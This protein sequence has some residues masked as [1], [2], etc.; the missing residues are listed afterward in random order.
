MKQV[1]HGQS[2]WRKA[3]TDAYEDHAQITDLT[4]R[5]GDAFPVSYT[6]EYQA[7]QCVFDIEKVEAALADNRIVL[8]LYRPNDVDLNKIRLKVYHVGAPITLSEVMPVL[9]NMGLRVIA[10]LPFEVKP[11]GADQ[12]VWIH[13]FLLETPDVKDFV[14]IKDVK[15]NFE[16]AFVKICDNEVENDGLNR[17][18]LGAGTN[19]Q[20]TTILRAYV[21][22]IKQL[23]MPFSRSYIEKAL[24]ENPQIA[25]LLISMFK[26]QHDPNNQAD[27]EKKVAECTA[28]IESELVSVLSGDFDR[29]LRAIMTLIGCTLRTNYYQ[30]QDDGSEKP[31]LSL[32]FDSGKIPFMVRPRPLREIF[33]YSPLVEAIHLRGDMIAR[34]GLRWSDRHEDYR[35][36]VLGLMK[37]QMVKNAVIVPTGSKGGFVVK[38]PTNT[39]DEF[40][41]EGVRCYK[42]FI[43]ALLEITDNRSGKKII[44]PKNVVRREGDDPYLV[45]AADKGTATFSDI[46]NGLSQDHGFWLDDAFASGG[47][48]G[49]DHKKMGIT[50]RGAW[51]SVKYHFRL[52]NHNTQTEEFE[53][54][55][56]GD[57]GGD[58]F[59]NGMLLSEKIRLSGAF[60]HLHIF[61]DPDPDVAKS[62]KERKR[63]FDIMGGWDKYNEK[64]LSKGGRIYNRSE[65][66]LTLTPE[67]KERFDL[68]KD[69]VTPNELM[70]AMLKSRTDLL[71]FGGIGTYIKATK[72]S[73][74]A[75]GDKANDSLRVNADEVRAKVLGEGA[76]LGITQL[77]RVE[78]AERG[79]ALNTDFIDNSAGVDSSDHEVN[80]KIL[81]TDVMSQKD[82]NMDIKA[83]NKLLEKMTDEVAEHVLRHNYQ[84]AQAISL[85]EMQ[86][87]E[88][89]Q[90]HEAFISR[91]GAFTRP[92]S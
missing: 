12:S 61:C 35:T 59:G 73:H 25:R 69:K 76:N 64:L 53:V 40:M 87:R 19:W 45:V 29:I 21:R 9:E 70:T 72:E 58:V 41:A 1:K 85:M 71:W 82:Y 15:E 3:L 17:L 14:V 5:Y 83:R 6:S 38:T 27:A 80:I 78:M 2:V 11:E 52:F 39:R 33:V 20:E 42:T 32:K 46:A 57:M 91:Y 7:K 31:Y 92:E 74:E 75:A 34:G 54:V 23:R 43:T 79:I 90:A 86:A 65:K 66:L 24:T 44:P 50:A 88:N 37:A 36:E 84:Q 48:A 67:I 77:G 81:L 8:N 47:S 63:L 51:E 89:L 30:R 68:T 16:K 13:D 28:E 55:G 56:V 49:Y 22:Y 26:A 60:N 18:V 10:E 62:F 4:L